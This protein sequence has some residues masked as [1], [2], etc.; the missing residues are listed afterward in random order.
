MNIVSVLHTGLVVYL[1]VFP[2]VSSSLDWIFLHIAILSSILFHWQM[3]N[4][5]CALTLVEQQLFPDTC[6]HDLFMQ[7]LVGPVYNVQSRDI[8]CLTYALLCFTVF[9][10][11]SLR[12][13]GHTLFA[14]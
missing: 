8:H 11:A 4:D 3:N 7:R 6:K 10:Y 14:N 12:T 13:Q 9:R 5:V 1:V 2:F